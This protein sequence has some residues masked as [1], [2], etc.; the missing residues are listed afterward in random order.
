V[1][2]ALLG[3]VTFHRALL[4]L[5]EEIA[6][7]WRRKCGECGARVDVANYGRKPRSITGS[8]WPEGD[9][10]RFSF[11]C[12]AEGCRVRSTP[13]SVRFLGRRVYYGAVVLIAAFLLGGAKSVDRISKQLG[14]SRRTL[15][16][17]R[18]WWTRTFPRTPTFARVRGRWVPAVKED[19]LPGSFLD[20]LFGSEIERTTRALEIM[21]PL[22]IA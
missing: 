19:D 13:P 11:C 18:R 14:P 5:D 8:G 6:V 1:Y 12:R 21:K 10:I 2:Q 17:W 9:A 20:R 7:E 16:R 4:K 22:T 15:V 3:D